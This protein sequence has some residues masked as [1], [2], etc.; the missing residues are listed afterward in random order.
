M[1]EKYQLVIALV[2]SALLQGVHTYVKPM[3]Q[4]SQH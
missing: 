3:L 2:M 4:S 1:S